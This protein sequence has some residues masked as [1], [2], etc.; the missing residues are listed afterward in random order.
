MDGS[1]KTARGFTLIELLVVIAIIAMLVSIL[2]PSLSSAKHLAKLVTC[3][4]NFTGLGRG[5]QMYVNQGRYCFP[6]SGE[7]KYRDG[8]WL[9]SEHTGY[10]DIAEPM[11]GSLWEFTGDLNFYYCP[12]DDRRPPTYKSYS[13]NRGS[14]GDYI[15][16]TEGIRSKK[17]IGGQPVS[18]VE[19]P[20]S[21]FGVFYEEMWGNN[22][23]GWYYH[24]AD[25]PS[26]RHIRGQDRGSNVAFLDGHVEYFRQWEIYD[27]HH[28]HAGDKVFY[29]LR[30]LP[31]ID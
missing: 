3:Q 4:G 18:A 11:K 12:S 1:S 15:W 2:L 25:R 6:G 23:C 17:Y 26:D 16:P 20:E 13:M 9:Y 30:D 27:G 21:E 31:E 24:Q 28:G 10:E 29:P 22:G 5:L 14:R 7:G 8:D 19:R